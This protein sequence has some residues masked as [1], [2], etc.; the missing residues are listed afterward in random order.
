MYNRFSVVICSFFI[1][2]KK[3]LFFHLVLIVK[4]P[5]V[6]FFFCYFS[7]TLQ[8]HIQVIRTTQALRRISFTPFRFQPTNIHQQQRRPMTPINISRTNKSEKKKS[9]KKKNKKQ[10]PTV[11]RKKKF[12]IIPSPS[13]PICYLPE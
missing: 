8:A 10:M 12:L 7:S 11:K 3:N 4:H 1:Q 2:L 9:R 5:Y 6:F 13:F